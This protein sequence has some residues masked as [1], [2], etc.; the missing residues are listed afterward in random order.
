MREDEAV[1]DVGPRHD[2]GSLLLVT[3]VHVR[4]G[5]NGPQIDD[6]SAAGLAQWC[7]H[8]DRVTYYGIA[9]QGTSSS[10]WVDAAE[11]IMGE[12][13]R[14]IGLPN[15]YGLARMARAYPGVRRELRQAIAAHRHLCF[16][17]GS[18]VGD[19]P[20]VAAREAL[21][22]KRHYAAWI[23]RVEPHI[24]RNRLTGA[25]LRR[26]A[27]ELILPVTQT[28]I[29]HALRK[30]TVA[31]LQG[32]DTFDYYARSAPDPHCT[33]DTHTHADEQIGE[34]ERAAKQARALSGAPIEIVYLGRATAMKGP[35]DWLDVLHR[36]HRD[37]VPFR[38]TWLGDGPD[39]AAMR[40][41]VT[42]LGLD[43]VVDLPGFETRK[44]VLLDRLKASDLLLFCHKTPESARC[45]IEAL[46]CGCPIV[47]YDSAYP[48]D[49]VSR[50]GGGAFTTQNDTAALAAQVMRLHQDRTALSTLI[51]NAATSGTHYSE[52]AVYAHRARLMQQA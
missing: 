7:R 36:L 27:A 26:L 21:R 11:G 10:A 17:L 6:Q 9:T 30:S 1:Q 15:G 31:L 20:F 39:L 16:T 4:Q 45:L 13:A 33:Y 18:V 34:A 3:H 25:P 28:M 8:F 29:R 43:A 24:I 2:G 49:L 51:E 35:F 23:D 48:R 32:G 42:E 37:T 52:D 22:Q 38:A 5:P 44:P 47:G 14:V 40:A 50:H 41:R 12:R 46:V 19:W